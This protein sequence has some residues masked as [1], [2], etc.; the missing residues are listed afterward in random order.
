M[1]F[2]AFLDRVQKEHGSVDLEW[3]RTVSVEEAK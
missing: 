3:L 1:L 2:Q